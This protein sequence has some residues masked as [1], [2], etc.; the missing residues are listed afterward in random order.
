MADVSEKQVGGAIENVDTLEKPTIIDTK[1]VLGD[2]AFNQAMIKEPPIPWNAIAFVLYGCSAI[3]FFC[4][5]SNGFDSSM[6]GNLLNNDQFLAFFEVGSVG[7]KAGI[8]SSMS[9]IG[10]VVAI[11]FVGPALDTWGRRFGMFIGAAVIIIGVIIQ[12]T[13]VH[14]HSVNQFMG[15]RFFMGL[16]VQLVSSAGPCYVV[17]ISH[18]AYRGT[19]TALYNVFWPVG[20]IVASGAASGV[21]NHAGSISWTLP[22]WLQMMFPGLV[23]I[24]VW[25]LPESPRWLYTNGKM[26]QAKDFLTKYHGNGNPESEWV[27]L[28]MWEYEAHLELDGA[29]KR[30]WDYRAL[31]RDGPSRYRLMAN[32]LT[33]LFGQWAGNGVVSYFL[34]GVLETAG[35]KDAT[36]R[37][38]LFVAMNAVQI[39]FAATGSMFVDT[40]GRRPMLIWVNVGCAVCWIGVTAASG[41]QASTGSKVSSGVTVA[42]IYLFQSIYSFGWT[43]LQ[44]LYPV[45]V[46]SFEMRA[47]GMAFSGMFVTA[48]TLVNQFGFPVALDNIKWKTYA[49]FLVWCFIQAGIIYLLMPETKNRTLEELDDIFR[50]KNPVKASV[51][52]RKLELDQNANVVGI[53]DLE[54]ERDRV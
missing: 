46:L 37:G 23:F 47:K 36:T 44:A 20:A 9:Q 49:V 4:S 16:G 10:S 25:L 21:L 51:A 24:F 38:H 3:G 48:G 28:Q 11:P 34:A 13:C 30:W 5:T 22:I 43:P 7:I 53:V 31:F 41:V 33:S 6:F 40:I 18:P 12:G 8:V 52:K 42:M 32:C 45:E 2:E 1:V 54:N 27:K 26:E 19:V 29:D 39:I 50:A 15:G 35:I 14:T 17:E